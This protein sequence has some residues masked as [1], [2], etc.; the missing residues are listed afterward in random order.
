MLQKTGL[1]CLLCI[2]LNAGQLFASTG[3]NDPNDFLSFH[4]DW[5][6]QFSSVCS[7]QTYS[8]P[9]QWTL[10]AY[11]G[12]IFLESQQPMQ[13]FSEEPTGVGWYGNFIDRYGVVYN[14]VST[15]LHNNPGGIVVSFNTP[16]A[17]TGAYIQPYFT[18]SGPF[19]AS[20]QLFNASW[21]PLGA[22]YIES[23]YSDNNVGT[24]IY[25]GAYDNVNDVSYAVFHTISGPAPSEDFGITITGVRLAQQPTPEPGT[26]LL[27]GPTLLGLGS[28]LRRR[29][30]PTPPS[31]S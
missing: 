15:Y 13:V 18:Y 16:V 3:S 20:F 29:M 19:T 22:P 12:T 5:C 17:G 31:V 8:S 21:A 9:Q 2:L 26:L 4:I 1:L 23:G 7:G 30:T 6:F 11:S 24:A 28:V 27:L 10:G 25:I 14:G